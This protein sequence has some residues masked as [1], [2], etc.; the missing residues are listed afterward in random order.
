MPGSGASMAA[1]DAA[2]VPVTLLTGF[3]G[4]GKTT[5]L[6]RLL[7][8]PGAGETAVLVN[9]F[10]EIGIDHHLIERIDE[11]TVL[12][13]AGCLCCTVQGDLVEAL[14]GLVVRRI[15]KEIPAFR[16]VLIET[17]GLA[18]PAPVVHT[19]MTAP[20][21][22]DR[23]ALDGIVAVVD[24]A[25]GAA[26]LDRH[27]ES[28]K[29]AAVADRIVLAKTDLADAAAVAALEARL[30]ALNPAAPRHRARMGD[31]DPALLFGCGLR[32]P[33]TGA[34][35][36]RRWLREEAYDD[37]RGGHRH[38]DAISAF[39]MIR[40]EPIDWEALVAWVRIMIG[41]HGEKL[42]RI[43]GILH[44]AGR[45]RP[46]ALHGVQHLFHDPVELPSWPDDDRRSRIVVIARGLDRG[47]I[48]GK[49]DSLQ[50][51]AR[52]LSG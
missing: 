52:G 10:G 11:A 23:Y 36:V 13:N 42:L 39:C 30:A 49:L 37:H 29:Q 50:E 14:S 3:L 7:R 5:L 9:E 32:D 26:T 38:D 48:E 19:L 25:A 31:V 47:V 41:Q 27:A 12:L 46:L 34:P 20:V 8:H 28:V 40:D 43:K 17:T 45:E 4:A 24:A 2:P 1:A 15:R 6:N 16:R 44:V 22:S 33:R 21:V 18:D 51:Q 35:D